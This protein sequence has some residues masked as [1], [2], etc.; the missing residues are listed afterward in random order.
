MISQYD[1]LYYRK[2]IGYKYIK[3]L[4]N[5]INKPEVLNYKT[6]GVDI[7]KGNQFVDKI[8]EICKTNKVEGFSGH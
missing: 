1:N 8:K 5:G 2:D 7:D 6:S 4:E 3:N